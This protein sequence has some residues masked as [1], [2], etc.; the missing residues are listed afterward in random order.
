MKLNKS[1]E[2]WKDIDGFEGLYEV[3][4]KGR[5]RNKKTNRI[6]IGKNNSAGYRAVTLKGN[7]YNIHRLVALA[8]IPNP[9]NL[10]QVDHVDENKGNNDVSNL[11]WV[12]SSEN[13]RHSIYKQCCKIKQ[14]DKDGNLINIWD[15]CHQ[16]ERELGYQ[17]GNIIGA[18][19]GR[20]QYSHGFKWEYMNPES[21]RGI[22]RPVIV[23]RGNDY[24]GTFTSIAKMSEVLGLKW[25]SVCHCLRRRHATLH[26]YRFKYAE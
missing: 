3:S 25:R 23:Y 21:Q 20:Q 14:I 7:D 2:I 26:G 6:F 18:C 13:V 16:I 19:K 15:S 11:R 22:N 1:E 8:F 9:Q 4:T 24:V 17:R 12:T 10:P 5:V